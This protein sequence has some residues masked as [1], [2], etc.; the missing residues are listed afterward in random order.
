MKTSLEK[1][2][3]LII[4]GGVAGLRAAIELA[5]VGK[6]IAPVG[7]VT[8]LTKDE[9]T[10]SSTGY[11]Q[12]G[13]AV[14]LS[15]EDRVGI[16]YEDTI[17]AGD[18]LCNEEAVKILVEEGP[19]VIQELISWG[20][21]F[22]R[23][24]SKL[25]FTREAAHS[26]RRI[27]HSHGDSTGRELERV[28]INKVRTFPSVLRYDFAF[29]LDLIIENNRC[30]GASVLRKGERVHIL[31]KAV[32]LATGGA[33]RLYVRT[34]NPLITTG[35]GMAV[36]Y[37]AGAVLED[38]EFVQ[39][40]PTSF[41]SLTAPQFLLSEALRGEG[42]FLRNI[43]GERFISRYHK[44]AELAPRDTVA[45]A[46]ISEMVDTKAKHVYLD[47][48]HLNAEFLQRR[49]PLTC[50]TCLKYGVDITREQVPV[51]PAAHYIMGG[52]KT[53]LKGETSVK[54][55][56]AAGEVAC[57]G[58]HGANRLASNSLLEGLVYGTR[59][60]KGA[61]EYAKGKE[62]PESFSQGEIKNG[63]G[64]PVDTEKAEHEL[65]QLMW[66]KVG[67][68]RCR[69]SLE[70]AKAQIRELSVIL[71]DDL[72]NKRELELKN[73]LTVA[74][75]ITD[76]ALLREGSIGA[77]YRSDCKERGNNWSRHT[78]CQRDRE[79]TWEESEREKGKLCTG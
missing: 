26:R 16:H 73:M 79:T 20:A 23:E 57:T 30:I 61:I 38:M 40:H 4:G 8:V 3:F 1:T 6:V 71:N 54:G 62:V 58:V 7:K 21:E 74:G 19:S 17:N 10:E 50:S 72:L 46:I 69:E 51:S 35:D 63:Q 31:A 41:Y 56:F 33:G 2:D 78:M 37:R 5:P 15:D 13:I 48:T 52:V 53:N 68:I 28:L 22:D 25:A 75:L 59:A 77:H 43:H 60:G 36:S 39:F 18:G 29:T 49:F 67:I 32:V 11:A 44:M 45:R 64:K 66:D 47:V 12:G 14:A 42:A 70:A 65:R 24:G 34:T 27:L 76:A 55:L 9:P